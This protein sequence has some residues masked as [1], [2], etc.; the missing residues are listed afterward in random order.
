[1]PLCVALHQDLND[2]RSIKDVRLAPNEG[3][4]AIKVAL[5]ELVSEDEDV[6]VWDDVSARLRATSVEAM[7]I[8]QLVDEIPHD[9]VQDLNTS[10]DGASSALSERAFF[11]ALGPE[12][13]SP[14]LNRAHHLKAPD[15]VCPLD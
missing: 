8:A 2:I 10:Q 15:R 4:E 3:V 7:A 5:I 13:W 1:V 11:K 12:L 6:H 14:I 9:R